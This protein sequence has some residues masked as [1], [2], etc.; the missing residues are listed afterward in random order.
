MPGA[1]FVRRTLKRFRQTLDA[2][3]V[4]HL[5]TGDSD[6][7][8]VDRRLALIAALVLAFPVR[9]IVHTSALLVKRPDSI[10]C[11]LALLHDQHEQW[12][13]EQTADGECGKR[14][15]DFSFHFHS[16]IRN[17]EHQLKRIDISAKSKGE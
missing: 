15:R 9:P 10:G 1:S 5:I 14:D 2:V 3:L 12:R 6:C 8:Y 4:G 13:R 11:F 16:A 17:Q 7:I